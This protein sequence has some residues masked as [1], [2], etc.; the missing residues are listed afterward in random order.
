MNLKQEPLD[1]I[2]AEGVTT[3]ARQFE[4]DALVFATGFDAITGALLAMDI[5]G[6][7]IFRP[8]RGLERRARAPISALR[9]ADFPTCSSSP[10]PEARR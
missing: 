5:R 3:S 8:A 9:A 4:L 2:T 6:E 1:R 7:T 10:A